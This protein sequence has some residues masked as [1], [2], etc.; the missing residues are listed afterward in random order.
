MSATFRPQ[1]AETRANV[2][3]ITP[4][5]ARSRSPTTL[6]VSIETHGRNSVQLANSYLDGLSVVE[7]SLTRRSIGWLESGDT[8]KQ[9]EGKRV[10]LAGDLQPLDD[11][12]KHRHDE[13]FAEAQGF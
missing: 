5:R 8:L 7:P 3:T 11:R 6:S 10:L 4:I 13:S 9:L 1:A 2:N 12:V